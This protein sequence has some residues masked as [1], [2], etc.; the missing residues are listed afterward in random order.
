MTAG[1][2]AGITGSS[3]E[4]AHCLKTDFVDFVN[5]LDSEKTIAKFE[6]FTKCY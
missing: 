2:T 5:V 4:A 6:S 3:M 1:I